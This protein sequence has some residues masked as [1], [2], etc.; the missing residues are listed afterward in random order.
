MFM[1]ENP[2][3]SRLR[4]RLL[5]ALTMTSA[6]LAAACGGDDGTENA[7]DPAAPGSDRPQIEGFSSGLRCPHLPSLPRAEVR[8]E[9]GGRTA[10]LPA[11]VFIAT[12]DEIGVRV[13]CRNP[14]DPSETLG[15]AVYMEASSDILARTYTKDLPA[16]TAREAARGGLELREVRSDCQ[17]NHSSLG[18]RIESLEASEPY[19]DYWF[20]NYSTDD[21][22]GTRLP[23]SDA[24]RANP[25]WTDAFTA[26][27]TSAEPLEDMST[28]VVI[29]PNQGIVHYAYHGALTLELVPMLYDGETPNPRLEPATISATF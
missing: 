18:L 17:L 19:H 7:G 10:R 3:P 23:A 16:F 27:V 29:G 21:A 11:H 28:P 12:D 20:G 22:G 26:E 6:L 15:M 25:T 24:T 9:T 13:L 8:F 1:P 14:D 5:L 4:S 2:A